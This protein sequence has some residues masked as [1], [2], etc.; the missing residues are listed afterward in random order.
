[1]TSHQ[2]IGQTLVSPESIVSDSGD[3]LRIEQPDWE[4]AP[5]GGFFAWVVATGKSM[6]L[7]SIS[8]YFA[9]Y[10]SHCEEDGCLTVEIQIHRSRTDLNYS[11]SSSFGELSD[12]YIHQGSVQKSVTVSTATSIDLE[13]QVVGSVLASWEGAVYGTDGSVVSPPPAIAADGCVLSWGKDEV[14]GVLRLSYTEEHD[15]YTL[16]IT[17]RES[18]EYEGDDPDGAYQ[19]TLFAVWAGGAES[20]DVTLPDMSGY[21]GGGVSGIVDLEDPDADT[22]YDLYVERHKCTNEIISQELRPVACP[23][24]NQ[25]SEEAES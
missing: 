12:T 9:E 24:E 16:T 14:S 18:G 25:A 4:E 15:A 17:P 23:D 11:I 8:E 2:S 5:A 13:V 21:C 7:E 19:S 22:C 6:S 1:M 10:N 20:H 3:W